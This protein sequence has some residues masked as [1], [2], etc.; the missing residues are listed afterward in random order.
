MHRVDCIGKMCRIVLSV[1]CLVGVWACSVR[2]PHRQTPRKIVTILYDH[3]TTPD[4]PTDGKPTNFRQYFAQRY[5]GR[6]LWQYYNYPHKW[7]D[8]DV[9]DTSLFR[10][11][12]EQSGG[13]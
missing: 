1:V 13:R 10:A 9:V 7:S 5:N 2:K 6:I 4:C 11:I 12:Y 3:P 8:T